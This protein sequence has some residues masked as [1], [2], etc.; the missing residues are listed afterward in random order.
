MTK[1]E[2]NILVEKLISLRDRYSHEF[3]IED[4]DILAD[5]SN[6]I[7]HNIDKIKED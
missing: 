2:L 5:A 1:L 6:V 3:S 4:S 7:Y